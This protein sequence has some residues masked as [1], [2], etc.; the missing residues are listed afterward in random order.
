MT[1][2]ECRE[3]YNQTETAMRAFEAAMIALRRDH[4]YMGTVDRQIAKL[5]GV[6]HHNGRRRTRADTQPS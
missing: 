3:L 2:T 6:S 5:L 1:K 4:E